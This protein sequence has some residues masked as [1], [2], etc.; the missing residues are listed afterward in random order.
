[1]ADFA[2]LAPNP[3]KNPAGT[4]EVI[5]FIPKADVT[6]FAEAPGASAATLAEA[7]VITTAHT[8]VA[9]KF[10][11][12][13]PL[14]MDKNNLTAETIGTAY[15]GVQKFTSNFFVS[16]LTKEQA[17]VFE[18]TNQESLI[19][20]IPLP[21]GK[22]IQLGDKHRGARLMVNFDTGTDSS[23]DRGFTGIISAYG[24]IAIYEAAIPT[25]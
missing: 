20:M 7:N 3:G 13:I 17:A 10:F 4:D 5:Y 2:H 19:I 6:T 11:F 16:G 22:V 18:K 12:K 21:D 24:C 23:G 1:M 14:T 15:G 25:S 9:S 8:L